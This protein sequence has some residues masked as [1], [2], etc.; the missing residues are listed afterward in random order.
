MLDKKGEDILWWTSSQVVKI[1]DYDSR[2]IGT[3]G[4][5]MNGCSRER[6][7]RKNQNKVHM[8][9]QERN[10]LL[11]KIILKQQINKIKMHPAY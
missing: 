6:R 3:G 1:T 4:G 11:C 2:R 5:G 9:M 7:E 10:P 8:K